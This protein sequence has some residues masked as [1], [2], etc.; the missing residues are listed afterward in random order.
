MLAGL[1]KPALDD[2]DGLGAATE[3]EGVGAVGFAAMGTACLVAAFAGGGL[4]FLGALLAA[5][6]AMAFAMVG[7]TALLWG[8]ACGLG[9]GCETGLA[10]GLATVFVANLLTGLAGAAFLD[11]G[12]D[13]AD[14][15]EAVWAVTLATGFMTGLDLVAGWL[16]GLAVGLEAGLAVGLTADLLGLAA[17]LATVLAGFALGVT[18][19]TMVDFFAG[20][21]ISCLLFE[22]VTLCSTLRLP[23]LAYPN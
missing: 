2:L 15:L 18:F 11:A 14:C 20:A 10:A 6:L 1:L 7:G 23:P 5:G 9:W 4:V 17:G 21:F 3:A 8:L 22:P 12:A 13:L 16:A 19:L